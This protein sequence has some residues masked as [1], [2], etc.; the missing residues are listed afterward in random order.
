METRVE[1]KRKWGSGKV[2]AGV[3]LMIVGLSMLVDRL[4]LDVRLSEHVWPL[5]LIAMGVARLADAGASRDCQKSP[6]SGAWLLYIGLWGL[7]SEFHLFGLDYRTSWPLLVI[8][9]GAGIVWR[10]LDSPRRHAD[11]Q[12]Q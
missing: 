7:I 3:I 8:G 9:A 1:R 4:D 2:V 12:E 6:R 10:A 11:R 5:I